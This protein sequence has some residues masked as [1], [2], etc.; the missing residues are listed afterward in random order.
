[1]SNEHAPVIPGDEPN[2]RMNKRQPS[3]NGWSDFCEAVGLRQMFFEDLLVRHPGSVRIT[4][5]HANAIPSATGYYK[6]AHPEA[7]ARFG[8]SDEDAHL[9]RLLWLGWWFEWALENCQR[10]GIYNR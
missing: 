10:P 5:Q 6:Q 2:T 4:Q 9:A 1:M 7:Q 3:Y 8:Y